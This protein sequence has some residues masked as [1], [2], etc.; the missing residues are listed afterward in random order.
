MNSQTGEFIVQGL[1][2]VIRKKKL[3]PKILWNIF[4]EEEIERFIY[5]ERII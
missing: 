1:V 4:R 5:G 3:Q 2:A